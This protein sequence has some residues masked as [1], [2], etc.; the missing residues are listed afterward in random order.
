MTIRREYSDAISAGDWRETLASM[1]DELRSGGLDRRNF[2]G[3]IAALLTLATNSPVL[4]ARLD[5]EDSHTTFSEDPWLTLS[6]AQS[7]LFPSSEDSPGAKE[8]NATGYLQGALDSPV[9]NP[10]SRGFILVGVGWLNGIAEQEYG[11]VFSEFGV[12]QREK[13]LRQIENSRAG[14]RWIAT[15]LL[16]TFEALLSDPVYGGNPDG[17]GWKWL[18]HQ[19][20]FPRPTANKTYNKLAERKG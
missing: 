7:H 13:V 8:I 12:D 10:Y 16:Y 1:H 14:E 11:I 6:A 17:I 9:M 4:A 19:S 2:L 5:T 15:L 3:A 18:Q 20:G